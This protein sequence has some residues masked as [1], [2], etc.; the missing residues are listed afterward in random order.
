VSTNR[1][2]YP[3]AK[4][5]PCISIRRCLPGVASLLV[6]CFLVTCFA[7]AQEPPP[8]KIRLMLI[9]DSTVSSYP[10]PPADR[11]ELTGWGQVLG[12]L[13]TD[14]VEVINHAKS[15]RSSKSFIREGLWEKTLEV[16]ADYIF[17]QFG[18]NDQK[19]K[20][21]ATEAEGEFQDN[22]KKY[23][24]EA[25]EHGMKPILV[26]PVARRIFA[27][28][29]ATS[30]L[31]PYATAM[32]KV[33]DETKT[34]VVDL[35]AS[36]VALYDKLGDEASA[37]YTAAANDRTHFSRKGALAMAGLVVKALREQAPELKPFMVRA[38]AD[39]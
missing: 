22:L 15:G 19:G 16:K 2:L 26:T 36:S 29:K 35:H 6:V 33:G 13:F 14:R 39:K 21:A 7:S 9:G 8:A 37:D 27:D 32:K 10:N 3:S 4:N 28:G 23:I 34:P 12:E 18:H 38:G 5:R 30:T 1:Q 24:V 20:P 31:G 25:R 17:I 11:P